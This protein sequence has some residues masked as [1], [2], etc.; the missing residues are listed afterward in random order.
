METVFIS[1]GNRLDDRTTGRM[2]AE[3][4]DRTSAQTQVVVV[5]FA[6]TTDVRWAALC[7]LARAMGAW[8]TD[9]REVVVETSRPSQRCLLAAA[10]AL[11]PA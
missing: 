8:R 11:A 9:R 3:V 7:R 5:S 6:A 4:A 10:G 1:C 2:I